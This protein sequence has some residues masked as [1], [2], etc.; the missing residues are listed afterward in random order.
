MKHEFVNNTCKNC[1]L[2]RAM[3]DATTT[4]YGS[5]EKWEWRYFKLPKLELHKNAGR[6]PSPKQ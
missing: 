6:C 4:D 5:R 3:F 1:G 2:Q